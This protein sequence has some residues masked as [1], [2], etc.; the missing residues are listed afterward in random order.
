MRN[1]AVFRH[2][3][4]ANFDTSFTQGQTWVNSKPKSWRPP[5]HASSSLDYQSDPKSPLCSNGELT[6]GASPIA[7]A[8]GEPYQA[9]PPAS[10]PTAPKEVPAVSDEISI[11][12]Y[13][14]IYS[15]SHRTDAYRKDWPSLA[16]SSP[17]SSSRSLD[18]G[19]LAAGGS[20][21]RYT[22]PGTHTSLQY[23]ETEK[24]LEYSIS[25]SSACNMV[26]ASTECVQ[27]SCLMRCFIEELAPWVRTSWFYERRLQLTKYSLTIAMS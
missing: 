27:E 12:E 10:M 4:T 13:H 20:E 22:D 5:K 11:R 18:N 1:K 24:D 7:S 17:V 9:T 2:G 6:N 25:S 19:H 26:A 14:G 8:S 3:S 16:F 23:C 15:S 21:H